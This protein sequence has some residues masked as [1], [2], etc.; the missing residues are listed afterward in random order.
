MVTFPPDIQK[1]LGLSYTFSHW[2]SHLSY[3]FKIVI[4]SEINEISLYVY[5]QNVKCAQTGSC[6]Y[7]NQKLNPTI[8]HTYIK[9]ESK[10]QVAVKSSIRE[11]CS[12]MWYG[13]TNTWKQYTPSPTERSD[14]SNLRLRYGVLSFDYFTIRVFTALD[15]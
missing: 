14:G 1:N 5:G 10:Y 4:K 9:L 3:T 12:Q 7:P 11:K 15:N 13:T 2:L 6:C 8:W